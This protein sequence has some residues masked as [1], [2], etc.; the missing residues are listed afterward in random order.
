MK[1]KKDNILKTPPANLP[2]E[3]ESKW[4]DSLFDSY[5]NNKINLHDLKKGV[6][7]VFLSL[8]KKAR[9]PKKIRSREPTRSYEHTPTISITYY[10]DILTPK[11]QCPKCSRNTLRLK[12][13]F[14]VWVFCDCGFSDCYEYGTQEWEKY[15][16]FIQKYQLR[17]V[18]G[19]IA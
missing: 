10:N 19:E 4:L 5:L 2:F 8:L 6:I 17:L 12:A 1:K 11:T 15:V 16:D 9:K 14:E 13:P 7:L 3:Y 18:G